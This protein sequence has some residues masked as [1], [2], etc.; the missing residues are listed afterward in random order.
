MTAL[1]CDESVRMY[2]E[3]ANAH[4]YARDLAHHMVD[5]SREDHD[6]AALSRWARRYL[7]L[8]ADPDDAVEL[9]G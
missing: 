5:V 8:Q 1:S 6:F 7:D 4:D 9:A 2:A 3:L